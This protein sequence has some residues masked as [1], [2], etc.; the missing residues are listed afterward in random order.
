KIDHLD[1]TAIG[2]VDVSGDQVILKVKGTTQQFTLGED[3]KLDKKAIVKD[4]QQLRQAL[5]NGVRVTSITGRVQGWNGRFPDV[6]KALPG[7]SSKTGRVLIVLD[8]E[9]AK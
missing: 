3:P 6:M 8:F 7:A 9:T 5:A 1:I 2:E 4:L